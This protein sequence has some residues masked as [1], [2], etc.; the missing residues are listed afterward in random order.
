MECADG[1]LQRRVR[2]PRGGKWE[3]QG[4]EQK[5]FHWEQQIIHFANTDLRE[6][7]LML[8]RPLETL[9]SIIHSSFAI[10]YIRK[11]LASY[12]QTWIITKY[13]ITGL[14]RPL[15]DIFVC[16]GGASREGAATLTAAIMES[17]MLCQAPRSQSSTTNISPVGMPA[18]FPYDCL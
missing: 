12:V 8:S 17:F 10:A 5:L 18:F 16:R 2:G 7:P 13:I 9:Q 1:V 11:L 15:Q 4:L 3:R 14:W 6:H